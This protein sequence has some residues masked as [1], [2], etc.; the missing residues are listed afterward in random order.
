MM[1]APAGAPPANIVVYNN[2]TDLLPELF[3]GGDPEL[4]SDEFFAK[5]CVWLAVHG[6]RFHNDATKVAAF[7]HV[8]D[9]TALVWFNTL[10]AAPANV[11]ALR[12]A[13]NAKF[14]II[15]SRIQWKKEL[16]LLKYVPGQST[17]PIVNR[18]AF[19]GEK[20]GWALP[21]Q[22]ERFIK[23]LPISLRQFVVS[24][25]H[26]TFIE[27]AES[28][29]S[30]QELIEIDTLTSVF[31]NVSFDSEVCTLCHSSHR[32]L[33]CPALKAVIDHRQTSYVNSEDTNQSTRG[34]RPDG[35]K[36]R[37]G[38]DDRRNT[39]Q[40]SLRRDQSQRDRSWDRFQNLN[41]R[42]RNGYN[43]QTRQQDSEFS[44][45][46]SKFRS[47]DRRR[48]YSQN[49]N[50]TQDSYRDF[51]REGPQSFRG[52]VSRYPS[53]GNRGNYQPNQ[54]R[55]RS[56]SSNSYRYQNR[57][58][59]HN[60]NDMSDITSFTTSGGIYYAKRPNQNFH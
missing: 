32:S 22:I 25:P 52:R 50:Y 41:R 29:K 31:K 15:K 4:D 11:A 20:I 33:D 9:G 23:I 2:I 60:D 42:S 13:F 16:S 48:N 19:I 43:R 39:Q 38:R 36:S 24:R 57:Q 14:R 53:N 21:V 37:I 51:D 30:Y 1:A 47:P 6:N 35:S 17:L 56:Q 34:A 44:S 18:F 28:I 26:A 8:L 10:A 54:Y 55:S 49:Q 7:R 3:T 5:Y 45:D 12:V 40:R 27:V 59:Q 46:R 58:R